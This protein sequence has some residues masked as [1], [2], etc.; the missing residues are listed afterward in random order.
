MSLHISS[1]SDSSWQPSES[2]RKTGPR[3]RD[4]VLSPSVKN[5]RHV[6]S[7]VNEFLLRV[8]HAATSNTGGSGV[9]WMRIAVE[10]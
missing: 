3:Y 8:L 5:P 10:P 9:A 1:Y 7:G 2:S 4:V 6:L